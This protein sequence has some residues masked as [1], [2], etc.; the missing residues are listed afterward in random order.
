MGVLRYELHER[1]IEINQRFDDHDFRF[2]EHDKRF[3]FID[4]CFERV[5]QRFEKVENEISSFAKQSN[6]NFSNM[7]V[8]F[9]AIE[10]CLDDQHKRLTTMESG[11]LELKAS[12]GRIEL[13]L[14]QLVPVQ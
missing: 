12:L 11:M 5:D 10:R 8:R 4:A 14:R 6:K 2:D 9:E 1:F 13:M 7:I 3:D